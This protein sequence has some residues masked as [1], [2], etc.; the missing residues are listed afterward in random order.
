MSY[1]AYIVQL[2]RA[3]A[4][5]LWLNNAVY[6]PR[7]VILEHLIASAI[8]RSDTF[9]SYLT[10]HLNICHVSL[11]TA[12]IPLNAYVPHELLTGLSLSCS[13][14]PCCLVASTNGFAEKF[15]IAVHSDNLSWAILD[16]QYQVAYSRLLKS[17]C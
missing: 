4:A 7:H 2:M 14:R 1:I 6:C 5:S 17:H 9:C 13:V 8:S 11:A 10:S 3:S 15:A 16:I 12:V